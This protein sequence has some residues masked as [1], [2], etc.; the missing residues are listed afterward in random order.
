MAMGE[1][2][3]LLSLVII[4][5]HV[6]REGAQKARGESIQLDKLILIATRTAKDK[7]A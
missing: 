4:L 2:L 5:S 6:S 1:T 3:S 7:T